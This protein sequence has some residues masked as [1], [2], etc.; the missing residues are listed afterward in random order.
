MV[1]KDESLPAKSRSYLYAESVFFVQFNEVDFYVEDEDSESL[2]YAIFS[3]LFPDIRIERIFPLGGKRAV[4][5]H[6]QRQDAPNSIYVLDKD[7]DDLLGIQLK[8]SNVFYLERFCIENH[9]LEPSAIAQFIVSEK[10]KL[11]VA[12][13]H[14]LFDIQGFV[15]ASIVALRLLFFYFFLVQRYGLHLQN[16]S[17]PIARFTRKNQP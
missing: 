17:S 15:A 6:A 11:T 1:T 7:F 10:P 3:R 8:K 4:L 14:K 5:E 2:Y 16:T 9:V 12:K 13:V